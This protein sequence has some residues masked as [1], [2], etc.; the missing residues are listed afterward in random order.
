MST[1]YQS[2]QAKWIVRSNRGTVDDI[3]SGDCVHRK[4]HL[5]L[6]N[7]DSK[8]FIDGAR[9]WNNNSA[10]LKNNAKRFEIRSTVDHLGRTTNHGG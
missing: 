9:W 1:N 3:K 5:Y 10:I 8:Y 2:S 4:D 7:N 6:Q